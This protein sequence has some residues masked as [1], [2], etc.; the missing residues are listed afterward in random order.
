MYSKKEL[1]Q[2]AADE[3]YN[4][5]SDQSD[6][7][8]IEPTLLCFCE[9]QAELDDDRPYT[10]NISENEKLNKFDKQNDGEDEKRRKRKKS[11]IVEREVTH[12]EML[13]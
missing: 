6:K 3:Y 9:Y 8:M 4:Y 1:E 11:D 7:H 2:L 13:W 12:E 5:Y 10:T